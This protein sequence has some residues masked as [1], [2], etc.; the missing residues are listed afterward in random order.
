MYIAG[1]RYGPP[2][3]IRYY[4]DDDDKA[5]MGKLWPVGCIRPV[6]VSSLAHDVAFVRPNRG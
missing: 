4:D 6:N 5:G 2:L 3:T 1:R